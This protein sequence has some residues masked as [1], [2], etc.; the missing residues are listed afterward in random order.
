VAA[1]PDDAL[2]DLVALVDAKAIRALAHPARLIVIDALY[3]RGLALTATAAAELA[4]ITPS[5]MSY[6]LRALERFGIVRRADPGGDARERPW[7][8]AA[9]DLRIRPS[10][11]KHDRATTLATSAVVSTALDVLRER[12]LSALERQLGPEHDR[13]L[14]D[15]ATQ[16]SSESVLVTQDEA[17]E[18]IKAIRAVIE[19]WRA[20]HRKDAPEGSG[21]L[22]MMIATYPE[23]ETPTH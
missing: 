2:P 3:D 1:P 4:G 12:L 20:E 8:R 21:I 16:F 17:A 10:A 23:P 22:S 13:I 9:R 19:P 5:A 6:H 14:L 18:L 15:G 7:V 11:G